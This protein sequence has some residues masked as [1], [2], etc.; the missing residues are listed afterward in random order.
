MK[1]AN[2]S[3]QSSKICDRDLL[4]QTRRTTLSNK[5]DNHDKDQ[6]HQAFRTR[7]TRG[8]RPFTHEISPSPPLA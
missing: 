7:I 5:V 8:L 1:S 4:Y 3:W 6:A 2:I